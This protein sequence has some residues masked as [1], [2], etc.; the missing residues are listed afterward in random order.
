ML[1]GD[2]VAD[3]RQLS[4]VRWRKGGMDAPGSGAACSTSGRAP[5]KRERPR[6]LSWLPKMGVQQAQEEAPRPRRAPYYYYRDED[7]HPLRG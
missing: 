3:G 7:E 2:H 4:D 1:A 6:W 5:S